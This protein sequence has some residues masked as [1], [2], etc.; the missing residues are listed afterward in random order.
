MQHVCRGGH[1]KWGAGYSAARSWGT[2][3]PARIRRTTLIP[4]VLVRSEIVR[5][6]S[7]LGAHLY[8]ISALGIQAGSFARSRAVAAGGEW[9]VES[10][11]GETAEAS[12]DPAG[13]SGSAVDSLSELVGGAIG[14]SPRF[15]V[16]STVRWIFRPLFG[17]RF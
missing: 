5:D 2:V 12:G 14:G 3:S 13:G 17:R 16:I 10:V 15:V 4:D 7:S 11:V 1:A 6:Y 8:G 9:A